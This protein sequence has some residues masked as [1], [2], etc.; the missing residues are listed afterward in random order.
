M[1]HTGS[2]EDDFK[3]SKHTGP[4]REHD[5]RQ[6]CM[7][8]RPTAFRFKNET[9][10]QNV[11]IGTNFPKLCRINLKIGQ[12]AVLHVLTKIDTSQ[13]GIIYIENKSSSSTQD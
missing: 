1:P 13:H 11:T 12:V 4:K 6:F 8:A 2:I 7:R 10:V 5:V 9:Y 3:L